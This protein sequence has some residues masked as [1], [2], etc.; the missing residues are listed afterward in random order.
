MRNKPE[1]ILVRSANKG[2]DGETRKVMDHHLTN[3]EG[4]NLNA[5]V[6]IIT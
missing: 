3:K 6:C 1:L 4:F 2:V 5:K